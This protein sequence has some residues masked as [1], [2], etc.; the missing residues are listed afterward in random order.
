MM[1]DPATTAVDNRIDLRELQ[2]NIDADN[3]LVV[4]LS[5]VRRVGP[6]VRDQYLIGGRH[7]QAPQDR[8][9]QQLDESKTA[10]IANCSLHRR[11]TV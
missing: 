6:L 7:N 5:G 3:L 9:E 4:D 8:H 1:N 10:S 2:D 11:I